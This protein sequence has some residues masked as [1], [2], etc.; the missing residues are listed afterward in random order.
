MG[1]MLSTYRKVIGLVACVLFGLAVCSLQA[2]EM[3]GQVFRPAGSIGQ[4]GSLSVM[5]MNMWH[6]D[7][8]KE[9]AI[10]AQRLR[11]DT[12]AVP[13]F[14]LCQEVVFKRRGALDNTAAVL[15]NELGYHSR[16]TKRNGDKEGLAIISKY[17]FTYYAEKHLKAQTS[18]LLLG[19][20]RVSVMGEFSVPGVGLV[21]VVNVHLTNWEF[22][23]RIRRKQIEETLAWLHERE[24]QVPAAMTFLGGDFNSKRGWDEMQQIFSAK[25]GQNLVF[26]DYNSTQPSMGSPG[27]PKKRIDFIFVASKHIQ[28]RLSDERLLWKDGLRDGDGDRFYISDHLAVS[29]VYAI[30]AAP[31]MADT[32]RD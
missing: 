30:P 10:V 7:K 27:D 26:K 28:P 29:H 16:G 24:S 4:A 6:R 22:E 1:M 23:H 3:H 11:Q 15:A 18:K 14:I 25:P 13:D 5:T 19:F 17:P 2:A 8:P 21:R 12:A 31:V 9:L 32:G 20:N